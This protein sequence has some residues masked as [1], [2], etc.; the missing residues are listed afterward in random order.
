VITNLHEQKVHAQRDILPA[1]ASRISS[2]METGDRLHLAL[3]LPMGIV[4]G[5]L[6]A[7]TS[8]H[9]KT[10]LAAYSA[11]TPQ[12]AWSAFRPH[13][14]S[15]GA[16]LGGAFGFFAGLI[17]CPLTLFVMASLPQN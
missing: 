15:C 2:Y 17:P 4:F 8:G 11:A 12:S 16:K 9:S 13:F 5:A 1:F 7:M 3:F 10:L 6:H 14:H